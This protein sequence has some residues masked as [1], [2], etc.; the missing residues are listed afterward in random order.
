MGELTRAQKAGTMERLSLP[1][2]AARACCA[3][4]GLSTC[5]TETVR[6]LSLFG[7]VGS[8]WHG[9]AVYSSIMH[10]RGPSTRGGAR[11]VGGDRGTAGPKTKRI[12][13]PR[14]DTRNSPTLSSSPQRSLSSHRGLSRR[15]RRWPR[16]S[17]RPS[18]PLARR[19]GFS[20]P[21]RAAREAWGPGGGGRGA[22]RG[23]RCVR[24]AEVLVSDAGPLDAQRRSIAPLSSRCDARR[25]QF[26]RRAQP[27]PARA[28]VTSPPTLSTRATPDVRPADGRGRV[29]L[30]RGAARDARAGGPADAAGRRAAVSR[31]ACP[32]APAARAPAPAPGREPASASLGV[33]R[34]QVAPASSCHQ[35][36][37]ARPPTHHPSA[38]PPHPPPAPPAAWRPR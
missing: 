26:L 19:R 3:R 17:R 4:A 7:Y 29:A 30:A 13:A 24:L 10:R 28:R 31:L 16:P 5:G 38:R 1:V 36:P 12:A 37:S 18:R 20:R 6:S 25:W 33:L 2:N 35:P 34:F 15:S 22:P 8:W 23:R 27:A 9:R 32:G 11:D 21:W 14:R